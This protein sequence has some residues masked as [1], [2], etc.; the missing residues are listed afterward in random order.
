RITVIGCGGAGG[1]AVNNMIARNLKGVEFMVCNT[2]AQHLSTTLTD[3]RLQLGRA[4][5]QGLGCG[6]NPDAG[7][8]AATESKEEILEMISGSH[9]AFIT[10][11]MGG[12]TG[13]G[14]APVIAETCMEAGILTVG[15]VTK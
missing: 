14:A 11:G 9:M 2:D 10:A 6:A 3:N 8:H 4:T 5:T 12:G 7:R 13:T 1:N 15:V